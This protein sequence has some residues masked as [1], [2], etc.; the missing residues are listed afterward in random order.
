MLSIL[1]QATSTASPSPAPSGGGAS[2][3]IVFALLAGVFYFFMIR[4]Q[5]RARRTHA[6]LMRVLEVG[7]EIET[8][9]GMFGKITRVEDS[10]LWVELAPSVVVKMSRGAVRRKVVK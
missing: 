6:E 9:A 5:Q 1:A 8:A 10:T 3:L 7:D 4:P 2:S